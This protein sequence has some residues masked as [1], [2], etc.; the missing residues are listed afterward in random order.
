VRELGAG[1]LDGFRLPEGTW[2]VTVAVGGFEPVELDRRIGH[3]RGVPPLRARFLDPSERPAL[4]D[5]A[6]GVQPW[7]RPKASHGEEALPGLSYPGLQDAGASGAD[8]DLGSFALEPF[9]VSFGRYRTYLLESKDE[10]PEAWVDYDL[11][12][13]PDELPVMQLSD[14]EAQRFAEWYGLRLPYVPELEFATRG[15]ELREVPW[16]GDPTEERANVY[17]QRPAVK[18]GRGVDV[19]DFL[20]CAEPVDSR[21]E[22]ATPEGLH[23]GLGNVAELTFSTTNLPG[24]T[25]PTPMLVHYGGPWLLAQFALPRLPALGTGDFGSA[26]PRDW[27]GFRC[28]RTR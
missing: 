23:H 4:L 8:V 27:M 26:L 16:A 17:H 9:E 25:G 19:E 12:M 5:Y 3:E 20:R 10:L 15:P 13:I 7:G 28:A 21:P 14:L 24:P 6:A 18:A 22:A 2:R 1:A 11:S